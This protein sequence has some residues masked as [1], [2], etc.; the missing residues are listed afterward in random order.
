MRRT[1]AAI[2]LLLLADCCGY[3][4][5]SLLPPHLRTVAVPAVENVTSRPG[6]GDDLTQTLIRAFNRDRNLRVTAI[7][8]ADLVLTTTLSSY[9]RTAT[10]YDASQ[11]ISGYEIAVA[12]KV[13]AE[14]RV[15]GESFLDR[16]VSTAL[17][18]A[19]PAWPNTRV[20]R[21]SFHWLLLGRGSVPGWSLASATTRSPGLNRSS[22][23]PRCA[24]SPGAHSTGA[25]ADAS[26]STSA[27]RASLSSRN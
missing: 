5:R 7:E 4:T 14:D 11:A 27:T 18:R 3:S 23:H 20:A 26:C 9:S 13:Q 2:A 19:A 21:S 12:A 22:N 25:A 15:R 6:G 17:S 10:A 8:T 1:L 16:V 24:L